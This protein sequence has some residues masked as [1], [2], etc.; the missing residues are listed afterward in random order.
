MQNVKASIGLNPQEDQDPIKRPRGIY[1]PAPFAST[2]QEAQML[3]ATEVGKEIGPGGSRSIQMNFLLWNCSGAGKPDFVKNINYTISSR[4]VS[5]LV[6]FETHV[7][8]ERADGI[9]DRIRLKKYLES[10]PKAEP[11]VYAFYSRE[12]YSQQP[13]LSVCVCLCSSHGA[14]TENYVAKR[15]GGVLMSSDARLEWPKAFVR[16]LSKFGSDHTPLLLSIETL[17]AWLTHPDFHSFLRQNWPKHCTAIATLA[18]MRP[19]LLRWNKQAFRNIQEHKVKVM[20]DI[21]DVQTR[22]GLNAIDSLLQLNEQLQ[23]ELD[24]VLNQEELL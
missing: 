2:T 10:K 5:I 14:P 13:E 19:K 15:L 8:G 17:A 21:E 12:D 9:C 11:E 16:H 20:V 4:A 24:L 7:L 6:V 22:I 3:D 1:E 23:D 18:Q